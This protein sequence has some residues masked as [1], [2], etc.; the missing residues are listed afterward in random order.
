MILVI[1][2]KEIDRNFGLSMPGTPPEKLPEAQ[3]SIVGGPVTF[4][5]RIIGETRVS[6]F[7]VMLD[8]DWCGAEDAVWKFH[9]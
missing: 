8:S 2:W 6:A 4:C 3:R 1:K 9:F 7:D 5:S